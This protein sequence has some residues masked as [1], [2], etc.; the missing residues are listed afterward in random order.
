MSNTIVSLISMGLLGAFFALGLV[1]ASKKLAVEVDPKLEAI[2]A[3]LPGVNCG[4]CGF[5][6]CRAFAEAVGEGKVGPNGC[7]V[8]GVNVANKIAEILGVASENAGSRKVAQVMCKGGKA[9]AVERAE[10]AGPQDCRIANMTQGGD[11]GCTY[12]CLGLGTCVEACP[13]NAMAMDENGLPVIFEDKCTG[14]GKCVAACP[15]DIIM[16][17]GEEYGVHIRCRSHASGKETRSVCKVGCIACRRCE[18]ECPVDA[19]VVE[20]NLAKID[21]DKCIVCRKCVAVCPVNTIEAQEGKP[22]VKKKVG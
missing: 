20:N 14:C 19:I 16:L 21:Y 10:Y 2:E 4:A 1:V 11:K 6:G 22:I 5:A 12:G 8:G 13:F 15:R 7:P 9:E 18:K 17:V 3:A